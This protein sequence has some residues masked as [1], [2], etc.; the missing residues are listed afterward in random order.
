MAVCG[1]FCAANLLFISQRFHRIEPRSANGR[2]QTEY[3][4]DD[5]RDAEYTR[6]LGRRLAAAYPRLTVFHATHLV[7]RAVF[8]CVARQ[9]GTRDIYKLLR[10]APGQ[11]ALPMTQVLEDLARL[12][13]RIAATPAWGAEHPLLAPQAAPAIDSSAGFQRARIS[14]RPLRQKW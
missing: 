7:S 11:A 6:A 9:A 8:D 4:S 12:R 13:A 1:Y 2:I 3:D 5:Q 10:L 14:S